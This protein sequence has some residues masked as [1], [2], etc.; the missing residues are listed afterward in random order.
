MLDTLLTF[1]HIS[2]THIHPDP[3]YT[4]EYGEY[5][6]LEGAQALVEQINAL[7]FTPDLILHTGDVVYDPVPEAYDT[8][9]AVLGQLKAP[10]YYV[11]GNHD[12]A[13]ALQTR[14]LGEQGLPLSPYDY[15]FEVNGVR[16][17]CVDSTRKFDSPVE[18][19]SGYMTDDQLHWLAVRCSRGG[20]K[21]IVVGVHHNPM[22]MGSPWWDK[23]MR[24]ANGDDF[25]KMLQYATFRLRGIFFGHIHQ[26]TDTFQDGLLYSSTASSWCQFQAA[27]GQK[28][29]VPDKGAEPGFSVVTLTETKTF[30]RRYRFA[31]PRK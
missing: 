22:R 15:E 5:G 8:A 17:I 13:G 12:D 24:L 3:N 19:P 21:P 9:K 16:F 4:G 2:D 26:N 23:Y 27:P 6:S 20:D 1:V 25:H 31:M 28:K 11:M 10:V 29:T 18:N 30:I 14:L 7:P